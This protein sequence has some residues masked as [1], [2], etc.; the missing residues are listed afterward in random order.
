MRGNLHLD[1]LYTLLK[2]Q[3]AVSQLKYVF[4][5]L[6]TVSAVQKQF[7]HSIAEIFLSI[8]FS[9]KKNFTYLRSITISLILRFILK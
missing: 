3:P 8:L 7:F 2:K 5:Q 9:F 1:N 4:S 6:R